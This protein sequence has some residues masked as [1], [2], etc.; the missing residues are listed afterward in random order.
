MHLQRRAAWVTDQLFPLDLRHL[1]G[2][3]YDAPSSRVVTPWLGR[4]Y[5]G[6]LPTPILR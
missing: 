3:Q 6:L 5:Q 2:E 4:T 1:Q